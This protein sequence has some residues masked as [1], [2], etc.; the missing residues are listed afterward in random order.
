MKSFQT[1][2]PL[3]FPFCGVRLDDTDVIINKYKEVLL[4][5]KAYGRYWAHKVNVNILISLC[6][7][8]LRCLIIPLCSFRLFAA[9]AH[10]TF[11]IINRG[12]IMIGEMSS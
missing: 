4:S 9:I 7:P 11:S 8:L 1:F 6:Y 5:F 2:E 12:D 3:T 10:I